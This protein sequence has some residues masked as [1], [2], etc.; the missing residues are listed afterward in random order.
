[1]PVPVSWADLNTNPALNSPQGS[2]PLGTQADDY[3]RAAFGFIKQL[4]D[5]WLAADG[6]VAWTGNQNANNK[7]LLNLPNPVNPQDACTKAYADWLVSYNFPRGTVIMWAG[8]LANK[9]AGWLLCDGT[10]GTPDC[11]DRMVAGAGLSYYVGQYGGANSKT[12]PVDCMPA[13][14]HGVA[15]PGHAH[16]VYDPGHGHGVS[17]PGHGHSLVNQGSVQAGADNGGAQCPVATGYSSG[18]GQAGTNPSGTGIGIYSSGTGIGVNGS[19]TGIWLYNTGGGA[20]FDV[21]PAFVAL[22]YL[23]KA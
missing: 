8:A 2:E 5:G 9:P 21:R 13:H 17:D 7:Y 4:H 19:G 14:A 15:D 6:S 22:Y 20:A 16:S 1:M 11:R 10:N 18:R 23:M 3:I 12:I